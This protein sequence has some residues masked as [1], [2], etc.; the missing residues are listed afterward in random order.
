MGKEYIGSQEHFE[1]SVNAYYDE[2]E[3]RARQQEKEINR[4]IDQ[5]IEPLPQ[6]TCIAEFGDDENCPHCYSVTLI[7]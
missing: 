2:L 4:Q 5:Q 7:Q 1:D 3:E 6:C